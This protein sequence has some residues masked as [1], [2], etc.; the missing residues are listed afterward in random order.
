M[1]QVCDWSEVSFIP[2]KFDT[3]FAVFAKRKKP[4]VWFKALIEDEI[5]GCGCLLLLSKRTAR[6]SN[7]FVLPQYRGMGLAQK[8]VKAREQWAKDQGFNYIDARS[9][10]RY[11]LDHGYKEIK[12]YKVGGSWFKK[13]LK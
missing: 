3:Q 4:E 5:A 1:I 12:K 10:K 2:Q 8:I 11:Y 6:L 13:E 9:V 7:I